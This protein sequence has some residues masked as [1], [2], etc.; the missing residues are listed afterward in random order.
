MH[1]RGELEDSYPSERQKQS[2]LEKLEMEYNRILERNNGQIFIVKNEKYRLL[3]PDGGKSDMY[4]QEDWSCMD[5]PYDKS[6][7]N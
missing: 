3:H 6:F 7:R 1:R 5:N 2:K 4:S